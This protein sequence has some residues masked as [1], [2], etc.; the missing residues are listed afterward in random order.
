MD[1]E[2]KALQFAERYG[3]INYNV[4]GHTMIYYETFYYCDNKKQVYKAMVDL[5]SMKESRKLLYKRA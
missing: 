5:R 1:Y 2:N 4:K 3:I